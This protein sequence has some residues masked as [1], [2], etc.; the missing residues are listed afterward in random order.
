VTV[1]Y[2]MSSMEFGRVGFGEFPIAENRSSIVMRFYAERSANLE[3]VGER[4]KCC[5]SQGCLRGR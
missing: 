3:Q 4:L 5:K 2:V 1:F